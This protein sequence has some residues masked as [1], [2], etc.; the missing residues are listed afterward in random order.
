MLSCPKCRS[1]HISGPS[2]EPARTYGGERLVSRCSNCGYSQ[3]TPCADAED[4]G[5]QAMSKA[6]CKDKRAYQSYEEAV[7][8]SLPGTN[9]YQCPLCRNFHSSSKQSNRKQREKQKR[10][11]R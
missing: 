2:Y 8:L 6:S 5:Q 7:A 1:Y 11:G 3:S 4:R 10:Y 9:I